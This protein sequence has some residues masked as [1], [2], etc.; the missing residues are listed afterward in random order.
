MHREQQAELVAR[1]AA[2]FPRLEG[3][4]YDPYRT[5]LYDV[6]ELMAGYEEGGYTSILDFKIYTHFDRER[7]NPNGISVRESL[8]AMIEGS[9]KAG[10]RSAARRNASRARFVWPL[11]RRLFP[12]L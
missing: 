7:R 11:A 12:R 6:D 9:K 5:S 10:S 2:V 4:P 3:L 1:G 8:A